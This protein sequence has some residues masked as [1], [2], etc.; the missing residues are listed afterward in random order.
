MNIEFVKT[1]KEQKNRY[2]HKSISLMEINRI[3]GMILFIVYGIF[4]TVVALCPQC[5]L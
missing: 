5:S 2:G 4:G 1:V 3:L